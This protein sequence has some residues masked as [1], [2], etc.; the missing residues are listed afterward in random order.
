[1]V[2]PQNVI[3]WS[4]E[5]KFG[6][7]LDQFEDFREFECA[8]PVITVF[9]FLPAPGVKIWTGHGLSEKRDVNL[10]WPIAIDLCY[11][12]ARSPANIPEPT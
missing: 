1:V 11:V 10:A 9:I 7:L 3:Q 5:D 12:T 4:W 6:M 8:M 2:K